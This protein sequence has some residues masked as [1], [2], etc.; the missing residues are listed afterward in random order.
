VGFERDSGIAIK[1]IAT[2]VVLYVFFGLVLLKAGGP[3][4][5]PT[6]PMR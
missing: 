6:S 5:S 2:V 3:T 1:I 4:F